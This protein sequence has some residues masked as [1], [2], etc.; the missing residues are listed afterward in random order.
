LQ[1]RFYLECIDNFFR[2]EILAKDRLAVFGANGHIE[3]LV[4]I[5]VEFF[6]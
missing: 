5:G 4:L 6:I 3:N 2:V 1:K